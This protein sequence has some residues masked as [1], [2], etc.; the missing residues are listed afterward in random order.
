MEQYELRTNIVI[1]RVQ[2]GNFI[3]LYSPP[4]A[5]ELLHL[6]KVLYTGI[7]YENMVVESNHHINNTGT[8]FIKC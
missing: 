7:A 3:A 1:K 8:Q 5:F 4:T 6:L 2:P